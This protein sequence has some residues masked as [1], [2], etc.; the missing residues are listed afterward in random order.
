MAFAGKEQRPW[1]AA[2]EDALIWLAIIIAKIKYA[3]Q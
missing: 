3:K 1:R 2:G